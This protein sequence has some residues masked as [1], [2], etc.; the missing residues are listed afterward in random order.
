M[1]YGHT[2]CVDSMVK[3]SDLKDPTSIFLGGHKY[4]SPRK[5]ITQ[6]TY[7]LHALKDYSVSNYVKKKEQSGRGIDK[8]V[9]SLTTKM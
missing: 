6:E 7:D 4:N 9:G 8:K 5:W 3:V 1:V 2:L